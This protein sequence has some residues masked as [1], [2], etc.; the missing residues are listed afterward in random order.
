LG[1]L[2]GGVLATLFGNAGSLVISAVITSSFG[3][4]VYIRSKAVRDLS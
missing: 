1:W 3:L 2:I 4:F